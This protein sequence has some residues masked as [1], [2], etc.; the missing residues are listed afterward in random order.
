M[1]SILRFPLFFYDYGIM[2]HTVSSDPNPNFNNFM[3]FSELIGILL[4]F[5]KGLLTNNVGRLCSL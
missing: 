3:R 1:H 5:L 2:S 4:Q